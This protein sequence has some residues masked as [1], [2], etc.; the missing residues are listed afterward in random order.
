METYGTQSL[1]YFP[2][3]LSWK[4][5][6]SPCRKERWHNWGGQGS[7][8]CCSVRRHPKQATGRREALHLS[9]PLGGEGLQR[10]W[11]PRSARGFWYKCPQGENTAQPRAA[12]S[13]RLPFHTGP[14]SRL[15]VMLVGGMMPIFRHMLKVSHAGPLSGGSFGHIGIIEIGIC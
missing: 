8:N 10:R 2:S 7:S 15:T 4:T 12:T 6:A 1:T 9:G 5:S 13:S 14:S 3:G 11:W